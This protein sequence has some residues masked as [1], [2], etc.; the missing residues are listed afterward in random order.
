M[1]SEPQG[2]TSTCTPDGDAAPRGGCWTAAVAALALPLTMLGTGTTPAQAAA[3]QCSVDYKT[4]DWGSGFTADLTITNRGTDAI[5]G[6]TLTYAYGGNQKLT[7]GWNGTWSQSGKTVTVK[8]AGHNAKIAAGA[9]VTTGAQ[10]TYS[11][12]NAAPTAFAVNGTA[13]AGRPPA[14]DRRADQPGRGRDLH[15]RR[16]RP[17]GGHR[18]G[19][20]QRDDQQG[21]VLHDTTLLGTDTTS[22]VH[23]RP[24]RT[25]PRA[26]TR[27]SQGVRQPGRVRASPPPSA[28]RRA[29][30]P[31]VVASPGPARASSRARPG[32]FGVKLSTQAVAR[33]SPSPSPARAATPGLTVTAR[34]HADL[35]ARQLEHRAEGD[36]RRRRNSGTGAATFTVD[37]HRPRQGRRSPSPSWRP[38]RRTT[39]ASWTCTTRSPTRRT[40]TSRPRASRTTRSRP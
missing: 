9:N 33:T 22:P 1:F 2:G 5:D 36:R 32:T 20:R 14:A 26:T 23:L 35:H 31:R 7:N 4:N 11:G 37:R 16:H 40:A 12:T 38:R 6:W 17:D 21:R 19:G 39:P 8:N 27:S 18:R 34:R 25:S 3:V 29:R 15:L 10:F 30:V 24:T 28:S 13:C